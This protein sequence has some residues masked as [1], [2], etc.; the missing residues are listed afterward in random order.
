MSILEEIER[1]TNEVAVGNENLENAVKVFGERL[2]IKVE[3]GV[4][5]FEG[6]VGQIGFGVDF[7]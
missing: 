5:G 2:A 1:G 7:E 3:N 6:F 4:E